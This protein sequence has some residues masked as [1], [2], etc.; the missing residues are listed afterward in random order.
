MNKKS[1]ITILLFF[2]FYGLTAQDVKVVRDFEVWSEV[3]LET[4]IAG[5]WDLKI[6]E[7]LR[8]KTDASELNNFFTQFGLNYHINKNFS[9]EGSY[10]IIK[11]QNKEKL[12]ENFCRYDLALVYKARYDDFSIK[13]RAKYQ[14]R[15]EGSNPFR[16]K[17]PY[18]IKLRHKLQLNYDGL[19]SFTP[20]ISSEIFQTQV[21]DVFPEYDLFRLK[22][23]IN[24]K[25]KKIGSFK[26]SYGIEKELNNP[27]PF[28]HYILGMNYAYKF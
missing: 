4:T 9:L 10:R 16:N 13:Y 14:K 27:Q 3:E 22:A 5:K 8:L 17:M 12:L 15:I 24:Y 23:G 26:L 6:Q 20:Y 21:I 2:I 28:T 7:E 18:E 1:H 25:I 19:K 11:N